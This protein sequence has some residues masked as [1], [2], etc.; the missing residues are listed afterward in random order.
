MGPKNKAL[1]QLS[2]EE[3]LKISKEF[4]IFDT[5]NVSGKGKSS[6][7][8][9]LPPEVRLSIYEEL[10]VRPDSDKRV[11]IHPQILQASKQI[12]REAEPIL[13]C[14][15]HFRVAL[16]VSPS[17]GSSPKIRVRTFL[18]TL[19]YRVTLYQ[20]GCI[21]QSSTWVEALRKARFVSV[22]IAMNDMSLEL[23]R[24]AINHCLSGLTSFLD[25]ASEVRK[26]RLRVTGRFSNDDAQLQQMLQP[27]S[28]WKRCN[29]G[30]GIHL[31]G[32]PSE[33]RSNL[34]AASEMAHTSADESIERLFSYVR[35]AARVSVRLEMD[36]SLHKVSALNDD[37]VKALT[38]V[39]LVGFGSQVKAER[40]IME[41]KE[42]IRKVLER[43]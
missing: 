27:V 37:M 12:Y 18:A 41:V 34:L 28:M 9:N 31:L 40:G 25:P 11:K 13:Y 2:V 14:K 15:N 36:K 5:P 10:L 33:V 1:R 3:T 43:L 20:R 38:K 35:M 29:P 24:L 39:G 6:P 21:Y 7:L 8:L 17:S 26:M 19:P 22:A 23:N 4:P 32:L 42:L 16:S 30:A